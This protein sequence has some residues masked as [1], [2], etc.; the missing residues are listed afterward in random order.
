MILSSIQRLHEMPV[1]GTCCAWCPYGFV[2]AWNN[3]CHS[4]T[5]PVC[6]WTYVLTAM[7]KLAAVWLAGCLS[8]AQ[9][10]ARGRMSGNVV[11]WRPISAVLYDV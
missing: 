2:E 6:G 5:H 4:R 3:L 7:Q 9:L 1:F 11:P 8:G 10:R